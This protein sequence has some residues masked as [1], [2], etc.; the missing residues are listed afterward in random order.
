LNW[1]S[2]RR[3]LIVGFLALIGIIS[4][5]VVYSI[6]ETR[7]R[8]EV[9]ALKLKGSLPDIP[10]QHLLVWIWPGS[11]VWLGGLT[12]GSGANVSVINVHAD[13]PEYIREGAAQFQRSCAVCHGGEARGGTGPDLV[14]FMGRSTDWG[15]LTVTKWGRAGTAM[16][17]QPVTD[18]QIWQIN[19][20]LRQKARAWAAEAAGVAAARPALNVTIE[21][22]NAADQHPDEWT[23]YSGDM[24]GLRHSRLAQIN[25]KNAANVRVAWAAQLRPSFKP[26]S[27]TPIVA[28][29]MIFVTEAPD[30]V[31]ALDAR[32]GSVI[33]KF[34]RPVD[35]SKLPL[36]CGAFN[37]GVAILGNRVFVATLDAYLVALDAAT[38]ARI[39]ETKVAEAAEGNS[40]TS[41]PL[42]VDGHVVVGV[43]GGEYGIR[44]IIAA[45]SPE[46]GRRLWQFDTVPK[47]GDPGSET[48]KGDSWKT[49]GASSWVTGVFDK[50]LD[51]I[52]WTTGN[53]WPPL[54]NS[55]REGD[56]LY[57]N[58][59]VALERK[60]G[61]MRWYYQFTPDDTHDWDAAQQPILADVN[62][63]GRTVPALLVANRNGLY[64][65]IDRRDGRFLYAKAFV[66]QTWLKSFDA[67]GKPIADPA[68]LPSKNGTLVW[69]WMHGG[70]NWWPPSYHPKRR[71]HFVPTVDAATLYFSVAM[72][73]EQGQMTM[74]GTTRLASN[75]P[76]I[77][78][79]KAI[80]PDTGK[81][82]WT[83]RL[84]RGD[85]HQYSRI[86]GLLSTDGDI[87]FGGF[88]NRFV[89]LDAETGKE[90]WRFLPGGL[91]NA[92]PATYSIDGVQ[93]IAAIA[94]N[95]LFAF[96]L[97][98]KP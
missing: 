11:S 65:A 92:G 64:Y 14:A 54:D 10:L 81:V 60:T 16:A 18:K 59:V 96:S 88:E 77:M 78:A 19:S 70:T 97:G 4:T 33:W 66:K 45:F 55:T 57:S 72:R 71:L 3:T 28:G 34:S 51:L 75:Q 22:L 25:R 48:W 23:M 27:A 47:R 6:P 35:P 8:A 80:E 86:G 42:V 31:V 24:Q 43:A 83:T 67:K 15:F 7:W 89:I 49:G 20:F 5:V 76:A 2:S 93:Y 94:S 91:T 84:D 87:V 38:G 63:Q 21:T 37:R 98:P 1:I 36:C 26:L 29:G 44:G 69:P 90:L 74:G 68:A 52:Y 41:A 30:G 73:L 17:A 9:V 39:W 13:D 50:N 95:V 40:M 61:K 79:I 85:F 56:N 12:E 62:W 82:R 58:S 32:N 46:D 53:P